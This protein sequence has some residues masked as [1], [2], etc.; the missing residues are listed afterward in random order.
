MA[1]ISYD[2]LTTYTDG[3]TEKVGTIVVPSSPPPVNW[4]VITIDNVSPAQYYNGTMWEKIAQ[5][6]TLIGASNEYE[7]GSFGGEANHTLTVD[8]LATH[9]HPFLRRMNPTSFGSW[10]I[11]FSNGTGSLDFS[12]TETTGGGQPFNIMQPY[13]VINYWKR[14][15]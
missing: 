14:V 8:E 2:L 3:R 10:N 15:A 9:S 4:V 1:D 5:G 6:R 11:A 12:Y 7:L 13:L